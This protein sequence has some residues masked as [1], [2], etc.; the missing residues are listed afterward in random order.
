VSLRSF[1]ALPL[2]VEDQT[3][4]VLGLS[5]RAEHDFSKQASFLETATGQISIAMQNALLFEQAQAEIAERRRVEGALSASE[6]KYRTLVEN[7]SV[8]VYR[9]TVDLDGR[10]L[11][12]NSAFVRMF[13]YDS[14][15]E[16]VQ[17]PVED[18]YQDP[19]DRLLFLEEVMGRG[20]VKDVELFLRR[21]DSKAFWAS[22]TATVKYSDS[23]EAEWLDGVLEDITDR[24]RFEQQ[25]LHDA[26][27][28]KLTG[29]PNRA[30]FMDRLERAIQRADRRGDYRFAVLYLDLD[31]F[32]IINDSL[33]HL[34]GDELLVDVAQRLSDC[35]REVDTVSRL[36][37]DEFAILM[38]DIHDI[39]SATRLAERIKVNFA[40][41]FMIQG[42]EMVISSSIGIVISSGEY[43]EPGEYLRDA[44]IAMYRAKQLG[45]ARY[46][47]FDI[48]MRD[49]VEKRL[50]LEGDLR[51]AVARKEFLVH[52]Q[53]IMSLADG[54]IVGFEALLRWMHPELGLLFPASFIRVAEETGI[55]VSINQLVL[56]E[57]CLKVRTWNERFRVDPLL[58]LSVNISGVQLSQPDLVDQIAQAVRETGLPGECLILEITENAVIENPKITAHILEKI[59]KLQVNIHLD[60][61][62][63]GYSSL[64]S[65][66]QIPVDTIK[67]DRSF[68]SEI[69]KNSNLG[70]IRTIISMGHELGLEIIAEGIE[71]KEQL[72][73]LRA[74]GSEYGQGYLFAKPQDGEAM[75][76]LLDDSIKGSK[77]NEWSED[78]DRRG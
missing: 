40:A 37:G 75:E 58:T 59:K 34:F 13:G 32:K 18:L 53:P 25:L 62:G 52:Y 72:T 10:F 45:K 66:R 70:L 50:K 8:G 12:V 49:E 41:P 44:D 21:R 14:V 7:L 28:D 68:V 11:H 27:H 38:E 67:V 65:L 64:N 33:G 2:I 3:V 24:K 43:S 19:K 36:S 46:E 20:F 39:H 29:L 74:L 42:N 15:E 54:R 56:Q 78:P 16:M 71:T 60:D 31:R 22:C 77:V 69:D 61:F 48:S 23:G 35:S 26:F 51:N 76:R 5:T 47:I 17:V 63:T 9:T 6:E 55:I 57:A 4:G 73:E 30:L 1:A